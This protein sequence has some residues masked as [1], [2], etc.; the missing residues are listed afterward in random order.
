VR[1]FL[2][3]LHGGAH[4]F[5]GIR[6]QDVPRHPIGGTS[7]LS[8]ITPSLPFALGLFLDAVALLLAD[9][10]LLDS[11]PAPANGARG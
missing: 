3:G 7:N 4:A 2:I 6:M 10:A 9:P 5:V 11:S 8:A 1:R